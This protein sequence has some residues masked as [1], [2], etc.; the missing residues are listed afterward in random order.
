MKCKGLNTEVRFIAVQDNTNMRWF[1]FSDNYL[2]RGNAANA[3]HEYMKRAA[4]SYVINFNSLENI[5]E[6]FSSL[7]E[8]FDNLDE[9][10]EELE[11]LFM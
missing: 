3:H 7:T 2:H 8:E 5:P 1:I 4:K 9:V 10:V 6:D 11:R